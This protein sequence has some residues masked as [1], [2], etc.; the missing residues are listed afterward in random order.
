MVGVA[1]KSKGCTIC[2]RRKIGCGQET[3][4]CLN[5]VQSGQSCEGYGRYPVFINRTLDGLQKRRPLEE[6]RPGAS[7]PQSHAGS[8]DGE[9]VVRGSTSP[10]SPPQHM[11]SGQLASSIGSG[12]AT[13]LLTHTPALLTLAKII[14]YIIQRKSSVFAESV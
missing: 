9:V 12:R 5:C 13:L 4:H 11:Q 7:K 8:S 1:G 2:R 14:Q 3:P 6:A 10:P